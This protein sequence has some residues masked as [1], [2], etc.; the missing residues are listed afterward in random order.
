MRGTC[1]NPIERQNALI[2]SCSYF[3]TTLVSSLYL[4]PLRPAR[5]CR[6]QK[7]LRMPPDSKHHLYCSR[8]SCIF[9]P[10][11]QCLTTE[12]TGH[13][14]QQPPAAL[15][16]RA[17][18]HTNPPRPTS[19]RPRSINHPHHPTAVRSRHPQRPRVRT[20]IVADA[21]TKQYNSILA[22]SLQ[23]HPYLD[24]V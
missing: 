14:R 10:R 11:P 6:T 16:L 1:F 15:R 9:V 20:S 23:L 22:S 18:S 19:A 5:K 13:L 12:R 24:V 21:Y 2:V 8:S 17:N 4:R 3:S 7:P